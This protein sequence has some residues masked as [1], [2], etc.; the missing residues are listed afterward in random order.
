MHLLNGIKRDDKIRVKGKFI[1]QGNKK[2]FIK[3]VTYGTFAPDE[4]GDQFPPIDLISKDFEMMEANGIN[5]IRTYTVPSLEMLDKANEYGIMLMV[6]LPWEQHI[7]FLDSN[8]LQLDIIRRTRDAVLACAEHSAILCYTIGNE[9]PASMVRWYGKE[10]IEK[11]LKQLYQAVKEVSPE[12]LVTYVNYP[13]TEYLDLDFLDFNCFNVYLENPKKLSAY[14][15]RLHN[16]ACNKPLVL[17]EIGLDSMRNGLEKQAS[18]LRWQIETIFGKGCAGMFVFAW[19]DAWW[20]GGFEIEDWDFGLVTRDRHPKPAL[21]VVS[22]EF[23][24]LPVA[25]TDLPFISVIVCTYNGM[26]TIR[27]CLEGLI[28]L[29]YP[30][31]EVIVVNDGST[32]QTAEIV[33]EYPVRLINTKNYGLSSAR[34]RGMNNA[35]GSILAYIDDD[36]YPDTHWLHYLAYSYI[37][38]DHGA[39]GGPNIIPSEDGLIAQCVA[40]APGGPVHVLLNDEIAEHIPG[41]NFSILKEVLLKIG[42]F[43]PL[44]RAAGDDVDACWRIQEAGYTIGYHPAAMVW[45]HRRSWLK[46]YWKQQQGYG[47][48]EALLESKWPERYNGLGHLAWAG[49]IYGGGSN[50][51]VKTKKDKIYYGTGGSALFQSVYQSGP[52]FLFAIPFMPEWY[53]FMGLLIIPCIAGLFWPALQWSWLAMGFSIGIF[54]LQAILSAVESARKSNSPNRNFRYSSILLFLYIIQPIA[55][56]SG[57]LKHGLTP[58]RKRGAGIHLNDFYCF[59]SKIFTHWSEEN[60]KS[61]EAWLEMIHQNLVSLGIRVQRGGDFDRWDIQVRSG[62]FT[63]ARGLLVIEEHGAQKQ[64]LKFKCHHVHSWYGFFT[65]IFLMLISIGTF[66]FNIWPLGI[67]TSILGLALLVKY[68]IDSISVSNSLKKGFLML[69]NPIEKTSDLK[70]VEKSI[71]YNYMEQNYKEGVRAIASLKM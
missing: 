64:Y 55:R 8:K 7:T 35:N 33:R 5:S 32:D 9:I 14:I 23:S 31:Y 39:I 60:W 40:D 38:S 65:I 6:G 68:I 19:T 30:N 56:L 69:G 24:N 62:W 54:I 10:K 34:N 67:F 12:S 36:A 28:K 21:Q 17:A 66:Y 4:S 63:K 37:H 45:H 52:S 15:S 47:K 18:V 42:G 50:K 1:Y 43:D 27:D 71:E 51:T 48:A 61:P 20:R 70:A 41:C 53:L 22:D 46:A 29:P 57:R 3:G 25:E 44:Y 16:L 26:S 58:W 13:T 11:F 2:F 49:F 59:T